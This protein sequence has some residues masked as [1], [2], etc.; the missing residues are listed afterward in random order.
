VSKRGEQGVAASVRATLAV[1][2][3]SVAEGEPRPISAQ[4]NYARPAEY[5]QRRTLAKR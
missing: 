4:A 2:R 5:R 3:G 1:M